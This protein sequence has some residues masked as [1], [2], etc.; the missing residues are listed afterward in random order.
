MDQV[1]VEGF[2]TEI[3]ERLLERRPDVP[4]PVRDV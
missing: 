3:R 1:E 2:E 4:A